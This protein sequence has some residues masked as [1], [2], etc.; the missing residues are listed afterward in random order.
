M[1][2][3]LKN[4]GG[5]CMRFGL[6]SG[7][8]HVF[9][10]ACLMKWRKEGTEEAD[11][12]RCCPTCR[13]LSDFVVPSHFF[14]KT[15]HDKRKVFDGY[16]EKL[17]LIPCKRFNGELGSCIFGRDCMFFHKGHDGTDMK[18]QD[19]TKAE[20]YLERRD[21]RISGAAARR[22]RGRRRRRLE[23]P[24]FEM[25]AV[26][27]LLYALQQVQGDNEQDLDFVEFWRAYRQLEQAQRMGRELG[28]IG[29][30]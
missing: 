20:L 7:C 23:I 13:E 21:R 24:E 8:E 2:Q 29:L 15:E 22:R 16:K 12:R 28:M 25:E 10:W 1:G 5:K 4:K 3:E 27:G 30:F 9:C 11:N 18:E 14:P 26:E 6:L 19:K 17:S